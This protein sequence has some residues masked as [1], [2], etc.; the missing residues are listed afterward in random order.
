MEIAGC[1]KHLERDG[2]LEESYELSQ[3]GHEKPSRFE[4]ERK[5]EDTGSKHRAEER[6]AGAAGVARDAEAKK[7]WAGD[8]PLAA[9]AILSSCLEQMRRGK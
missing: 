1:R 3:V 2:F 6:T 4:A 8:S 7:K 5:T 9:T